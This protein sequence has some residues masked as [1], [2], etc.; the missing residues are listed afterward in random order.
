M[1]HALGKR[2][3]L[4]TSVQTIPVSKDI[5]RNTYTIAE[6]SIGDIFI[7]AKTRDNYFNSNL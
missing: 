1:S 7:C 3:F 4:K 5:P 2:Q 6:T